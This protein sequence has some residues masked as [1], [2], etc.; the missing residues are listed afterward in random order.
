MSITAMSWQ[1]YN[2][3]QIQCNITYIAIISSILLSIRKA[4]ETFCI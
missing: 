2:L 4:I 1:D 3:V